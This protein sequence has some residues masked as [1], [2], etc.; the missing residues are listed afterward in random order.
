MRRFLVVTIFLVVGVVTWWF[1]SGG[2]ESFLDRN[3]KKGMD[4]SG[5]QKALQAD[6]IDAHKASIRHKASLLKSLDCG[7][8]HCLEIFSPSEITAWTDTSGS[9]PLHTAL[10]P[11]CGIDSVIGSDAGYPIRKDFLKAMQKHWF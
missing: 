7:C 2:F 6:V 3:F 5:E 8:F 1:S 11:S 9:E 10:C 4:E